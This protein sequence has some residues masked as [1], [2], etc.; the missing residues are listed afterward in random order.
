MDVVDPLLHVEVGPN[1][2]TA[3]SITIASKYDD[4]CMG[5]RGSMFPQ[6]PTPRQR[7]RS[8]VAHAESAERWR[9]DLPRGRVVVLE[10]CGHA[11]PEERP[12]RFLELCGEFLGW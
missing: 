10:D 7:T 6:R 12:E 1:E 8:V 9:R 11:V 4:V 3:H 2:S 5:E